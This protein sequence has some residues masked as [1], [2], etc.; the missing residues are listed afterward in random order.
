METIEQT[1]TAG[2]VKRRVADL[3]LNPDNPRKT[4]QAALAGLVDSLREFGMEEGATC[5]LQP[6]IVN[7]HP[8]IMDM[9]VGGEQRWHATKAAGIEYIWTRECVLDPERFKELTIRLNV[10]AGDWDWDKLGEQS[11]G[12]QLMLMGFQDLHLPAGAAK[13]ELKLEGSDKTVKDAEG[14]IKAAPPAPPIPESLNRQLIMFLV[15]PDY[16]ELKD[17]IIPSAKARYNAKTETDAIMAA[18]R[19]ER[20]QNV[21]EVP[22][23]MASVPAEAEA[24]V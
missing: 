15:K 17:V 5:S 10:P 12:E 6:V 2:L 1:A 20:A 7:R 24:P 23:P 19:W 4:N 22:A 21:G 18:L 3:I 13:K 9:I 14:A 11:S 16:D 8:E